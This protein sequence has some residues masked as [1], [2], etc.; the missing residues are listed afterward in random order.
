MG[1]K[2][3]LSR[4]AIRRNMMLDAT[5]DLSDLPGGETGDE[6]PTS[7]IVPCDDC[8][9]TFD[10]EHEGMVVCSSCRPT[11]LSD[12]DCTCDDCVQQVV[13]DIKDRVFNATKDQV[14]SWIKATRET[15]DSFDRAAYDD[16][17]YKEDAVD[18]C[19]VDVLSHL[20]GLMS[21]IEDLA[22]YELDA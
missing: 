13:V 3:T 15:I 11:D 14:R 20:T 19:L 22:R 10:R 16:Y 8:G 17:D 18:A 2:P 21:D 12:L 7:T 1:D 6:E 5:L 4:A 9:D